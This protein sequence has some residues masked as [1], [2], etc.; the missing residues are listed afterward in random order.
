MNP[1]EITTF[2]Q[3]EEYLY[4]VPKFTTKS[5]PEMTRAF[6]EFLGCPGETRKIVHVAGTNGKGS[7]CTYLSS[8]L[9]AHGYKTAMF[10]SPHLISMCERFR[11]DGELMRED[12]FMR[13]FYAVKKK[14]EE[15]K[16]ERVRAEQEHDRARINVLKNIP[17]DYHPTFFEYLFFMAM[18]WFEDKEAD[19]IVLETGLGGRLDATNIIKKP[20][21]CIITKIGIDHTMYL[22]NTLEEI[23][24]EKAG[25]I[26][27]N[28]PV[29]YYHFDKIVTSVIEKTAI[30]QGSKAYSVEG[31]DIKNVKIHQ[32]DID[33]C[34][35]YEYDNYVCPEWEEFRLP[36]V[37]TYQTINSTMA[38]KASRLLLG[39]GWNLERVKE[40]LA[41]TFW[42]GRM[43]EVLP[44]FYVDGAHNED[45]VE[46]F[47]AGLSEANEKDAIL[48]FGVNG[49]KDYEPMIKRMA[50]SGYFNHV[51]VTRLAGARSALPEEIAEVFR[52]YT[53]IDI[54]L[55]N[56]VKDAVDKCRDLSGGGRIYA[57]G[58]LYLVGEIKE[59]IR[60]ELL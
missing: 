26:K 8:I 53:G 37:A 42:E 4:N 15:L 35:F 56:S 2:K 40:T 11:I 55:T 38:V 25:I 43:E 47:L 19:Y 3:A 29:L 39:E 21:L 16:K 45:G 32:K 1:N 60:E 7:V 10:T 36:T 12:E 48:L 18:L 6:Y 20:E 59:L 57:V 51:V 44:N 52:R 46:A 5:T 31:T 49:D 58:S 14:L 27:K 54:I 28:V 30:L 17:S 33:F 50:E 23:A 41:C 13:Y 24:G 9:I 34:M 22:G